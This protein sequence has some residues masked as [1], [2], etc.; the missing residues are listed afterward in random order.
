MERRDS[1]QFASKFAATY[2]R[3]LQGHTP[4]QLD[5]NHD[6]ERFWSDLL[7]LD[8]DRELLSTKLNEIRKEDC[9]GKLK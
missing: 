5:P 6:A 9:L 3:L 1:I 8:V 2:H 4:E 7:A